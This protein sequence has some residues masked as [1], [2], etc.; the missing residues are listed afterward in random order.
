[1]ERKVLN[2]VEAPI[3]AVV[4]QGFETLVA[5]KRLRKIFLGTFL[6]N[7]YEKY[8]FGTRLIEHISN[9]LSCQ[10]NMVLY[11]VLWLESGLRW[12]DLV[13]CMQDDRL[14]KTV[15]FLPSILGLTKRRSSLNGVS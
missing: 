7:I 10:K 3:T 2:V 8:F 5:S 9:N 6:S 12:L 13:L 15:F 11:H 4:K 1:M 14:P